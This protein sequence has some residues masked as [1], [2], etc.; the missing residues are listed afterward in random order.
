MRR[1]IIS[2]FCSILLASVV[3]ADTKIKLEDLPRAVQNAVKE[4]TRNSTLVGLSTE[5]EKGQRMYEVETT[6]NGH[7][8]DVLVDATG[9]VV[10]KEEEVDLTTIPA[11]AKVAIEKKAAGG[12]VKKVETVTRGT[13]VSYEA[14]ITKNGKNSEVA[15]NA[16]GSAHK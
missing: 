10:E 4:L 14:E 7:R 16:D 8:R 3:C 11:A 15:V 9:A 2:A 1:L 6:S 13:A 12:Q 5:V